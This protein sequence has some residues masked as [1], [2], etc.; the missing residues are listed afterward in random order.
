MTRTTRTTRTMVVER[1]TPLPYPV[2]VEEEVGEVEEEE[3]EE[4]VSLPAAAA[5]VVVVNPGVRDT[6]LTRAS[7]FEC[8]VSRSGVCDS[9]SLRWAR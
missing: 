8:G 5:G 6:R 7:P 4:E 9:R 3:V 1:G 2:H